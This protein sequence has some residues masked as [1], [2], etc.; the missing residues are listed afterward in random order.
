MAND[1][2]QCNF[3]GRL[4]ADPESRAMPSGESVSNFRIAV[5]WK[6]KDKEGTEWVPVVAFGKL[7]EICNQYLAKGSQVF[8]S[9]RFR[10]RK[11]Q[12]KDGQD[13]YSTEI[14]AETMQMLGSRGD[15]EGKQQAS[16]Q[17]YK[18]AR[19]GG[20]PSRGFEDMD[21]DTPF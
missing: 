13:R 7:A 9:G 20:A 6:S 1:L 2:N 16:G 14:V 21:S 8:I 10:T 4:G 5:G 11:W 17:Q 19:D 18:R 15:S 12:D 3:I